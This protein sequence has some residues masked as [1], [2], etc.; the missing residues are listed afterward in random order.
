MSEEAAAQGVEG[1]ARVEERERA[2]APSRVLAREEAASARIVVIG[3]RTRLLNVAW[4]KHAQSVAPKWFAN[5]ANP[6]FM[7]G[8]NG[9]ERGR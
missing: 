8:N 6:A 2:A 1:E 5:K 4:T 9:R 7:Q 3:L